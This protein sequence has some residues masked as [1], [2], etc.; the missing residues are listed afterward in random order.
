MKTPIIFEGIE[1]YCSAF[2][3]SSKGRYLS[4]LQEGQVGLL[5]RSRLSK[6]C[7]MW[8]LYTHIIIQEFSVYYQTN[9]LTPTNNKS[10]IHNLN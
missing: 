4:I 2:E 5:I 8:S 7:I 3:I 9:L 10:K 6:I 1:N